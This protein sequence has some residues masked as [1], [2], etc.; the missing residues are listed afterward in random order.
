M[1]TEDKP[2]YNDKVKEITDVWVNEFMKEFKYIN[3][4]VIKSSN[5]LSKDQPCTQLIFKAC[6]ILEKIIDKYRDK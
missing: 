1:F 4:E 3:C 6:D 2:S 5:G